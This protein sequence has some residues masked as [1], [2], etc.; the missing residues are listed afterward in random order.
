MRCAE[1]KVEDMEGP[2]NAE[3]SGLSDYDGG[4]YA[5]AFTRW[6][7]DKIQLKSGAGVQ[8][9]ADAPFR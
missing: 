9:H 8:P 1:I 4:R 5:A 3:T 7:A 6:L 2:L